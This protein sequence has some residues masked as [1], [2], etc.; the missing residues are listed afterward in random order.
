[1]TAL[2]GWLDRI[3]PRMILGAALA[4]FLIYAWPG[5]VGW[6]TREHFLQARAGV[7]KDGH[8]PAVA[9]LVRICE[10]FVTGPALLLLLQALS[11]LAGLYMLLR[12]RLPPRTAAL[13]AGGIFVFPP[14]SGVTGLITKDALMAGALMIAI[15]LLVSERRRD[16]F[17]AAGLIL[18]ASLMRWNAFSATFVPMVLLFRWRPDLTGFRRYVAAVCVWLGVTVVAM[19]VNDHLASEREYTWYWANGY[20]DIAGTLHEME[21]MDDASLDKLLDGLPLR[22]HDHL[23]DRFARLYDPTK[24]YQLMR[25]GDY[26]IEPPHD[27]ATAARVTE[28]WKRVVLGHPAAYLRYRWDNFRSLL[29]L[30]R[31]PTYSRV[32]VWLTVIAA[33]QTIAELEHDAHPSR[34]QN[35]L[36][37]A[38]IWASLTP[39]YY[40]FIYAALCLVLLPFCVRDRLELAILLSAIGYEAALFFIASTT[41]FRYSQWLILCSVTALTLFLARVRAARVR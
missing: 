33:P 2:R 10:L 35:A 12:T 30:D 18:F 21:P 17:L 36:R 22:Y 13:A 40:V 25:D 3:S 23:N 31:S 27:D 14:I 8:P 19:E 4:L 6:D 32:Y 29:M 7:F 9:I 11:L 5:F 39:I 37:S 15:A 26:L 16:H 34:L 20:L 41:D 1:V 28:V 24:Y 38:A